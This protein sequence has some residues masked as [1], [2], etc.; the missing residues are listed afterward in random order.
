M[1]TGTLKYAK[2]IV[3]F[4]IFYSITDKKKCGSKLKTKKANL[5]KQE[6]DPSMENSVLIFP[7]EL[8]CWAN[9]SSLSPGKKEAGDNL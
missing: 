4:R 5:E 1:V 6:K 7:V 8:L 9:S 3:C 2:V